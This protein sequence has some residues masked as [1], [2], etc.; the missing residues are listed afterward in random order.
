MP[1]HLSTVP[2][3]LHG[4][5]VGSDFL[6]LGAS[7]FGVSFGRTTFGLTFSFLDSDSG[8]ASGFSSCSSS[9]KSEED[10]EE[11]AGSTFSLLDFSF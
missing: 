3:T 5:S 11:L 2:K 10:S 8:F 6:S 4:N 9:S 7:F 1:S